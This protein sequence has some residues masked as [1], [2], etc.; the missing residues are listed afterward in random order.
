MNR[1]EKVI[2]ALSGGVDSS[3]AAAL[4][5]AEG[6][7]VIGATLR[8][9]HPDPE[10]SASQVCASKNDENAVLQVCEKLGIEHHFI[11]GFPRFEEQVLRHAAEE[12]AC[13]RTPNPCCDCNLLVKFGML[14]EFAD[15]IGADRILT[16]HY[17]KLEH[18]PAGAILYRGDDLR[19]DQSYF[20]Y[21]LDQKILSKVHF[22]VGNLEKSEVRKI[23]AEYGFVTSEKPDSQDACFQ[24]PGENFGET[25]RRLCN[26]RYK[27]GVFLYNGKIVGRHKG[28]HQ[29][30]LGQRK[31][32]NVALGVPGY[33][34]K[35]CAE[36]GEITLVTDEKLLECSSFFVQNV[37]WQLGS[38]P[39]FDE[40]EVQVRYRSRAVQCRIEEENNG[41]RVYPSV[42]LRAVTPGQ[43]AVFYNGSQLLGGGVIENVD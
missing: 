30:T 9:K 32:L 16:G 19:K 23:A 40:M 25:L 13:G 15:Q 3:V 18:T 1:P 17:A 12:Y 6:H 37:S 43:A 26:L 10:F 38:R 31:G 29:Y 34:S 14:A 20:L 4:A 8:L 24:V 11:E 7:E 35:I 28:I 41:I 21:R 27:K 42:P 5:K 33:I 22:P 36:S 39:E 2:V